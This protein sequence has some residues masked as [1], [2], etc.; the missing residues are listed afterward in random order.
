M[1]YTIERTGDDVLTVRHDPYATGWEQRYL[2]VSDVH[3]DNPH[4]DRNMLKRHFDQAVAGGAGILSIGDWFDAMGGRSDPRRSKSGTRVEHSAD[5]YLDRL[6]DDAAAW[7]EPYRG[8]LVMM[9][10]GNHETSIRRNLETD[11]LARLC[12]R[13]DV[14]H[15]GYSGFLRYMFQAQQGGRHQL[16]MFWHHGDGGG[17]P[18]T[19][20]VIGT[21]R[22]A[23]YLPD[24][25]IVVTGHIHEAW[26]VEVPRVRLNDVGRVYR[27]SQ[28]HIQLATYKDEMTLSGGYHIEKG[29]GPKP[30]GGWW[31]VFRYRAAVPH[32]YA[33]TERAL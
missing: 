20:G 12:R 27:D 7:L 11:L 15:M 22:R 26:N 10:D 28:L 23:V 33:V 29:R 14:A 30:L 6:V 19:R 24:A 16:R 8:S 9:A 17:G 32:I 5:N 4:C 18:V 21:N 25:D 13:L 31:L 2:L 1:S 3:W